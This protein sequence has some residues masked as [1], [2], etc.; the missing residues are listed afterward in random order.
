MTLILFVYVKDTARVV[1]FCI[2]YGVSIVSFIHFLR[3]V[4]RCLVLMNADKSSRLSYVHFYADFGGLAGILI[5]PMKTKTWLLMP[6]IALG[7][8]A[9]EYDDSTLKADV[10]NLKDRIT[11]LEGQVNQMN[12]D[13][14]SL[15]DIIQSLDRQ[16]S[17]AG[18]EETS[19][20]YIL[21]FTDGNTITLRNGQDGANG[22]DAPVIGTDQENGIS[23]W[24]LTTGEKT[25]WLTD[26]AGNKLP[27][28][29]TAGITPLLSIDDNGYWTV[30][31]DGGNTYTQITDA[32][33]NPIPAIGKDGTPGTSGSDGTDGTD[34][35][36][37]PI[38]GI[39]QENG[40]YYWT[41]TTGE[42]TSWLTDEA[43]NKLPVTGTAG[44][45]PLLGIDDE[46]FWT[47]SYDGGNT[48]TQLTDT[49]GNPVLA[50]GKDGKP[51]TPGTD[52]T[53]GKDGDSFFQSVTQDSE[54]VILILSDG[55][56][57]NIPKAQPFAINF[58]QTENIPINGK[59]VTLTYTITGA[60]DD[61]Q[62]R[63]FTSKGDLTVRVNPTSLSEGTITVQR[64][65]NTTAQGS[66]VI[67]LLFNKEKTITTLLTFT[68]APDEADTTGTAEDYEVEEGVWD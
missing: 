44:I 45:T 50:V 33:G 36:D 49:Q 47:V 43:G 46:G 68:D 59:G 67:V 20:G 63:A 51:G 35:K 65:A 42:N 61:T 15:Q 9:C 3:S 60:D 40:I 1:S 57:I 38:I 52:G 31:Y 27:V 13:I 11:A 39:A 5:I 32:Q 34:G 64:D 19:G 6:L 66:E 8:T 28:T 56:V 21:R 41:L 55:T 4:W 58:Q 17:I 12:E 18:V 30:S 7:V 54:K 62:V 29:G 26:E 14:V 48:Y 16:I 22:K 23:Y 2:A 37:A 53:P 25:D 24:T 10:D